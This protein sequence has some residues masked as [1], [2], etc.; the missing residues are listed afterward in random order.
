VKPARVFLPSIL[1]ALLL[2]TAYFP[3]D[4]GV[5]AFVALA[6]FLTLVRAEGVSAKRRYFAAFVGGF[7]FF[8][9]AFNWIRV[10]HPMMALFAWPGVTIYC[11][12][13][14]PLALL[15]IRRIDRFK[16]P[17]SFSV[18]VVWT[19]LEYVRA[20]FPTGFSFLQP[21][22]MYQLI[23]CGWY[24]LGHA[25]H[26]FLPII[27][28]ADIGG[29][30][31]ITF[32]IAGVNGSV[33]DLAIRSTWVRKILNLPIVWK[34]P[35]FTAEAYV[36]SCT[37][38]VPML[39]ICY[40]TVQLA[41]R[42]YET[43]PRIAAVQGNLAQD[44]KM[45][46]AELIKP[47]APIPL[48]AEYG[49]LARNAGV[50]P[51][52]TVRKPD[53]VIWPETCW[54]DNWLEAPEGVPDEPG[55]TDFRRKVEFVRRRLGAEA[56]Q[57]MRANSLLGLNSEDWDGT[58]WGRANSAIMI[59]ATGE[60][61]GRYDKMHL[62][63]F[64]EY[65]PLKKQMPWLQQFTPYTHDYSCTPGVTRTLFDL[66]SQNGQSYK[67]G[68]LICYEDSDPSIARRYN[69]AGDGHPGA[70][71]L[72]NISNDGW[73]NGTEQHEEHLAICRFRA[74]ESRRSVVR[75][76]NMGISA[77]IDPDG[78]MVVLPNDSWAK[79]KKVQAIVRGDVPIDR[80]GTLYAYIGDWVPAL[81]W[82]IILTGLI[83]IRTPRFRT[84]AST[85]S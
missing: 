8:G 26:N 82:F 63:P 33:Y 80:T 22:G 53:L 39:L 72:V 12:L 37:V 57:L 52:P 19:A 6:P 29:V 18:A 61:A 16:L 23:G 25:V 58:R 48:Q 84:P 65:V 55:I 42:P 15:L 28:A 46:R 7:V 17:L 38:M 4:L 69:W 73:F 11:A 31:L 9:L 56:A 71:F 85:P 50:P 76:V 78:R 75:A 45:E 21:L 32:S 59:T 64:G 62:V 70:D 35:T 79:S 67:F 60:F 13:Y 47:D 3:L 40:G 41:H 36:A 83:L 51:D 81:C 74:V 43:G 27:Q 30:Y 2:W 54:W 1:S 68:V 24:F 20:H 77:I 49:P 14:W 10:A 66:K 34:R 5:M 44:A